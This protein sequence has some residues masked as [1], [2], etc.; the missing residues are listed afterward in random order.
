MTRKL[1]V[2]LVAFLW[3]WLLPERML[4][5]YTIS[6]DSSFVVITGQ[7]D[8]LP[9]VMTD[10]VF[11]VRATGVQFV[12]NRT[13][14]NKNSEFFKIYREM[15]PQFKADSLELK[16][17]YIRGAASPEGPYDNNKRLGKGRTEAL[18]KI[19][20]ADLND[21]S[22]SEIQVEASSINEDY[23][24][25]LVLMEQSDDPDSE[26][27]R[28]IITESQGVEPTIK[29]RLR[30]YQSGKLWRRLLKQYFPRLR[31]ARVMLWLVTPEHP[32]D[33]VVVEVPTDTVE[34]IVEPEINDSLPPIIWE[35]D[36]IL[37]RRHLLAARTNLL[38]DAWY[39][40]QFG[41][42][43]GMNIQLEYYPLD[44]HLT[45]NA[46]FTFHN[47]RH[48]SDYQFFQVRDIDL[49]ARWY[50]RPHGIFE[51]PY[52]GVDL[53]GS[54]YGIGFSK[55]KGW[56]GEGGGA[57]VTLGWVWPL[58]RSHRWRLEANLGFGYFYTRHDPYVY[59][60][61]LTGEE[62][63]KY[64]YDYYGAVSAFRKRNHQ[65]TWM[66]PTQAGI[67]ITYDILYRRIQR[68]GVGVR[69]TERCRLVTELPPESQQKGDER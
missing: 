51:G 66:G 59:G 48:W 57:G 39:Q 68:K 60:N 9:F 12:V 26:V 29:H 3:L 42:A 21:Y 31:S 11:N 24:Y 15:L 30:Q 16:R 7:N 34:V 27:V 18:L 44:G 1:S 63:G 28:Q 20:K 53:H 65:F 41:W 54:W 46:G 35:R 6:P 17:L 19:I 62:D 69:R 25:L 4:L 37:V 55:T 50:F 23:A 32:Q 10:S 8:S 67:S 38:Y 45:Y 49:E 14:V 5:A 22:Q 47:H 2:F 43:P 40:P 61:T 56:E 33:S 58:C 36:T 13:E 64:Y 52:A